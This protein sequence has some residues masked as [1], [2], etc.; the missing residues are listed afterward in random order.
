MDCKSSVECFSSLLVKST[1][2]VQ[3]RP[4]EEL[5]AW[6]EDFFKWSLMEPVKICP[7]SNLSTEPSS[8]FLPNHLLHS[9]LIWNSFWNY[10]NNKC[11]PILTCTDSWLHCF[12]WNTVPNKLCCLDWQLATKY[13]SCRN[14][15]AVKQFGSSKKMIFTNWITNLESNLTFFQVDVFMSVCIRAMNCNW[16][17]KRWGSTDD[18]SICW[19]ASEIVHQFIRPDRI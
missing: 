19:R 17:I 13:E 7:I 6:L 9:N 15:Y 3:L 11:K 12:G 18:E 14:F 16:S 1:P 4:I 5:R 2:L 10:E 8:I